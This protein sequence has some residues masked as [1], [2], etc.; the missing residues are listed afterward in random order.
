MTAPDAIMTEFVRL[1]VD[2]TDY[3][4]EQLFREDFERRCLRFVF[5]KNR[6]LEDY[7]QAPWPE[8]A[9]ALQVQSYL[10]ELRAA[11]RS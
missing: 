11:A 7:G 4:T 1:I 8:D 10:G 5:A 9:L 3:S 6:G 2:I